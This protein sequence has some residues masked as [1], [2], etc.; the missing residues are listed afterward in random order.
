MIKVKSTVVKLLLYIVIL[1]VARTKLKNMSKSVQYSGIVFLD[2]PFI[3]TR[4]P[5]YCSSKGQVLLDC[6][7]NTSVKLLIK[8]HRDIQY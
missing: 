7:N 8:I 2:R 3:T 4:Y 1:R 6:M 5:K